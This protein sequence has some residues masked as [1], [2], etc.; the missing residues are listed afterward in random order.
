MSD[1]STPAVT[2]ERTIKLAEAI[3]QFADD[4]RG[5]MINVQTMVQETLDKQYKVNHEPQ[6]ELPFEKEYEYIKEK[7]NKSLAGSK[8]LDNF[9]HVFISG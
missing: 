4:V 2:D 6:I 1:Y 5:R 8:K 9:T 3:N 7:V